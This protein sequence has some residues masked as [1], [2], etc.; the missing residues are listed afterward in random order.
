VKGANCRFE[1]PKLCRRFVKF[2]WKPKQGCKQDKKCEFF[3]PKL[4]WRAADGLNNCRNKKCRF[5]HPSGIKATEPPGNGSGSAR[6]MAHSNVT[7]PE[8]PSL[9]EAIRPRTRWNT[10]STANTKEKENSTAGSNGLPQSPTTFLDLLK[11]ITTMQEQL[12]PLVRGRAE[13][14]P[15]PKARVCTCHVNC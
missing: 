7:A 15:I 10:E 5:L 13:E 9:T 6:D 12:I 14:T 8:W 2:G 4:C 3:H 11:Q 1:H